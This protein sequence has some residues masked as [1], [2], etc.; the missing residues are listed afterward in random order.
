M[1]SWVL[2]LNKSTYK[3]NKY[4]KSQHKQVDCMMCNQMNLQPLTNLFALVPQQI[5]QSQQIKLDIDLDSY[6]FIIYLKQKYLFNF[7]PYPN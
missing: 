6:Q 1:I 7:I 5:F 4:R 3:H 2:C